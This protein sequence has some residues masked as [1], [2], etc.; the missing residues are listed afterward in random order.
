LWPAELF[1]GKGASFGRIDRREF[2]SGYG[3]NQLVR[4]KECAV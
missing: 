3:F 4:R 2:A 1:G